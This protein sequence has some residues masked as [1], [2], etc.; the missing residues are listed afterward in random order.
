MAMIRIITLEFRKI[1]PA[2]ALEKW[3]RVFTIRS[4]N[5]PEFHLVEFPYQ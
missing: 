1:N 4:G 2:F 5:T 3:K